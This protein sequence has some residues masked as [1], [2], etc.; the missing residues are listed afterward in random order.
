[1]SSTSFPLMDALAVLAASRTAIRRSNTGPEPC[2]SS[3]MT[4]LWLLPV[5]SDKR[6]SW[7]ASDGCRVMV[8]RGFL[9]GMVVHHKRAGSSPQAVMHHLC[10]HGAQGRP[11]LFQV[12]HHAASASWLVVAAKRCARSKGCWSSGPGALVAA[13]TVN[14]AIC[15]FG[16]LH[17]AHQRPLACSSK[18]SLS[19]SPTQDQSPR[20]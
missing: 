6:R 17:A 10:L 8:R 16:A 14:R 2:S 9:V 11:C 15:A 5:S 7:A 3:L 12:N 4:A 20:S 19:V 18:I 13:G 1:M